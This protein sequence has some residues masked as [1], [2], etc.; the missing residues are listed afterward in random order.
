MDTPMLSNQQKLRLIY[1]MQALNAVQKTYKDWW[2]I[3]TDDKKESKESIVSARI[4]D[5]DDDD[6]DDF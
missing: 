1:C 5:D 6:N 3:V 4:N 2:L